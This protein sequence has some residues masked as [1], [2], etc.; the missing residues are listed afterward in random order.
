MHRLHRKQNAIGLM[1]FARK[2]IGL[3][4]AISG[5]HV[6]DEFHGDRFAHLVVEAE[7]GERIGG[8]AGHQSH[9]QPPAEH[10]IDYSDFFN[11]ARRMMQRHQKPHGAEA[12]IF[13]ARAG[14]HRIEGRR[15]HPA[16]IGAEMVLDAKAVIETQLV[17]QYNFPPELVVAL[18]GGHAGLAPDMGKMR[19]FHSLPP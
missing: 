19:E 12:H 9:L 3:L 13:G 11:Q 6:I 16:F 4:L 15:R 17:G 14:A 1:M 10:L 2:R 8:D 7:M 18:A 5:A